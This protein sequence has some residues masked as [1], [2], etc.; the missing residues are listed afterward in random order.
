MKALIIVT[1]DEDRVPWFY[2]YTAYDDG[3]MYYMDDAGGLLCVNQSTK[4][5]IMQWDGTIQD[6][7]FKRIIFCEK[8]DKC[9]CKESVKP[10][11]NPWSGTYGSTVT[12][13][14]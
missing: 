1:E 11:K 13:S 10:A 4:K 2:M 14:C 6:L 5:L 7:K 8:G 9:K 12:T 3:L